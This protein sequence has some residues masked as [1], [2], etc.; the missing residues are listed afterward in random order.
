MNENTQM[1]T[2]LSVRDIENHPIKVNLVA[3]LAL[4][5]ALWG[6]Y[7]PALVE[8]LKADFVIKAKMQQHTQ[9]MTVQLSSMKTEMTTTRR[10]LDGLVTQVAFTNAFQMERAAQADLDKHAEH[11]P[12]PATSR[13]RETEHKLEAKVLLTAQYSSCVLAEESNCHLLR[14]QLLR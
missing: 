12:N 10:A 4:A 9:A 11:R 2:S 6:F 1:S 3:T 7:R 8:D 13:W 14:E 5:A